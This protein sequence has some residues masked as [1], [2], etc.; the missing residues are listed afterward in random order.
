MIRSTIR[1]GRWAGDPAHL[2][3]RNRLL[4]IYLTPLIARVRP[5]LRTR[6]DKTMLAAPLLVV[7]A[8]ACITEVLGI[9]ALFGAFLAGTIMPRSE[10]VSEG[11]IAQIRGLTSVILLPL[12][13]AVTGL[14]T[15]VGLLDRPALWFC[16][17]L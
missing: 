5:F 4:I 13:F 1:T 11:L 16:C 6:L 15:N 8:S 10:G 12:F 3:V 2:A 14:R 9:H 7:L 17:A